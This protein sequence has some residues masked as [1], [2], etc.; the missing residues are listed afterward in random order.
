MGIFDR[1][2]PNVERLKKERDVEGLVKA[3]DSK[4]G[5][6]RKDAMNALEELDELAVEAL[7]HIINES[8]TDI[9]LNA[10][11]ALGNIRKVGV[12]ILRGGLVQ[13]V[14]SRVT[15]LTGHMEH[16]LVGKQFVNFVSPKFKEKVVERYKKRISYEQVP[17][18]YEIE[19][20]SK[21]GSAIP[22]EIEASLIEH[23][24]RPADLVI[25]KEIERL[26]EDG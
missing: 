9:R 17:S 16:S 25:L 14:N 3:L 18:K 23:G 6:I 13:I 10:A 11:E 7:V 24:G 2:K 26:K 20:L 5:D 21:D 22:V 4:E 19:I 1:F 12:A 8:D 15:E